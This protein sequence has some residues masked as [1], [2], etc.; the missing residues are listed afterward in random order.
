MDDSTRGGAAGHPTPVLEAIDGEYSVHRL[1]ADANAGAL[2]AGVLAAS[3]AAGG[4]IVSVTRT[5]EETSIVCPAGIDLPEASSE[6]G[7]A[8][9]RVRGT[10]DFALTGILHALTGPLAAAGIPVFALSTFDTD[11]LLVRA[12]ARSA[13]EA[14]WRAA[15]IAVHGA[16]G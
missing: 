8:A 6:P 12:G 10:L 2:L 9:Y 11:Y 1:P 14:A 3:V 13:S 16:A 15:G 4:R 7:W 5:V